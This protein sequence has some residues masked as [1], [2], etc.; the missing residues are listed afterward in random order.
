[1]E[2]NAPLN[3]RF[4]LAGDIGGTKTL[5]RLAALR[6][7]GVDAVVQKSYASAEHADLAAIIDVFVHAT[8]RAQNISAACFAVAGPVVERRARLTNLP[9]QVDADAIAARFG[10]ANVDLINDFAAAGLGIAALDA[11]DLSTLQAGAAQ[12]NGTRAVVGAGTGLGV[13]WLTWGGNRYLAHA[14]EGGHADFA[15]TDDLQQALLRFLQKRHGR[16]SYERVLS[17]PGLAAIFDFLR[18]GKNGTAHVDT[19]DPDAPAAITELA[20]RHGDRLASQALDLFVKVY[21]AFAGNLALLTVATGGVFIAGG[22]APRIAARLAEGEFMR[23]FADKGRYREL[24]AR[25]PVHVV[26]NAEVGLIG[27]TH[28]AA[29]AARAR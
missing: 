4:V 15:P 11:G 16:V 3:E 27:A 14:S 8:G 24:L 22:I 29:L 25:V 1:M 21:G 28:E 26:M 12:E 19:S 7:G 9:W 20:L 5:L 6:D 13:T 10:I 17:G 2:G 23:A 18:D